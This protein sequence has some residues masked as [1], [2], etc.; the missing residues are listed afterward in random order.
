MSARRLAWLAIASSVAGA[1]V[2][3]V[4]CR[5]A[6]RPLPAD[7]HPAAQAAVLRELYAGPPSTWPEPT[8]DMGVVYYE[9]GPVPPVAHPESNPHSAAKERLG[10]LLFHDGRLSGTGQM[11]CVSCH[12]PEL[13]WADGRVTS[14]GHGARPLARNAPSLLN[15]GHAEELFWDGRAESLEQLVLRVFHHPDEMRIDTDGMTRGLASSRGYRALFEEAFGSPEPTVGRVAAAIACF[16][17]TVQ[18]DGSS[19]FDAFLGGA[20]GAL[21]DAA[22]RGLHLFRT[23][24]RCMNCHNG[25]LLTDG[26]FHDTGLS[27]YGRELEDLGRYEQT[28]E[29]SDVGHFRTPSLRN[30]ART[31]PYMHNG[32]FDLDGVLQMYTQGMPTLRRGEE[33]ANDPLFPRKSGHLRPLDLPA[34]GRADLA[35]FLGSL[36]E[37]RRT[38]R[39]ALPAFGDW[40]PADEVQGGE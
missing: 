17:R 31:A 20:T 29:P 34:T 10:K 4:A 8:Y 12:A 24:A 2:G 27:Y 21:S 14:L 37:R 40:P 32:L 25:P 11:A 5:A 9:L 15:S 36:T 13:G 26:W 3:A 33:H 16:V 23:R 1:L 35:A 28:R 38:M 6:D 30:V 22:V 7:E 18:S 19:D 39:V